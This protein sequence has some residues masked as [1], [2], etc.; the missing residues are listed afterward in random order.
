MIDTTKEL[1]ED[2]KKSLESLLHEK[3]YSDVQESLE[4]KGININDVSDEDIETLVAAKAK[5][6]MNG[7]KGFS[8][9]TAF[10][11]ALSLLMGV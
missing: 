2:T 11:L 1:Y 6:M 8:V 7:I 5:D 4:E 3:A 10:A 9:G